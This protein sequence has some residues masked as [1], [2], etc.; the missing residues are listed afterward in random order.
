MAVADGEHRRQHGADLAGEFVEKRCDALGFDV[1]HRDHRRP[2]TQGGDT[3]SARHQSAGSTQ[4]LC[5]RQKFDILG[6]GGL[7][8]L[9]G[10]HALGMPG[11]RNRWRG[12]EVEALVTQR[13][14][15]SDLSQQHARERDRRGGQLRSGGRR[16]VGGQRAH[17]AQRLETDRPDDH[18]FVGD[19][20][21]QQLGLP[22]DPG[23]FRLDAGGG[24]DLL[25]VGQ[26]AAVALAAEGD[27]I[28]FAG[29]EP[30]HER[31]GGDLVG[32]VVE[33]IVL[34]NRHVCLP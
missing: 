24:H 1:G 22:D 20:L 19:R 12:G 25:E 16:L 29:V 3:A 10:Q 33:P 30:V 11:R 18:Q 31:I 15:G 34:V 9:D 28:G 5:Q 4:Q 32:V 13:P 14:D 2:V 27:G 23:Q 17:P 26:P 6:A 8:R 7:E 21:Q